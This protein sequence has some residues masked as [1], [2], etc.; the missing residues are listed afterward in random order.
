MNDKSVAS[1]ANHSP[2]T[3]VEGVRAQSRRASLVASPLL[4]AVVVLVR[5]L[6]VGLL[7]ML[8]AGLLAKRA[9][10]GAGRTASQPF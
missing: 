2:G 5:G 3:A 1:V 10:E 9:G 6:G 7:V 8:L 4:L